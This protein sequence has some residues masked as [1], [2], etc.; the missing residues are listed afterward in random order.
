MKAAHYDLGLSPLA[1]VWKDAAT[2]RYFVFTDKPT[3]FL[4]LDADGN[5]T[6]LEGITLWTPD[7]SFIQ[8]NEVR[9]VP[10]YTM[11]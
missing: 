2:S 6:T 4:R 10:Y 11:Y 9:S 8:A 1:L 5:F 3:I 7:A